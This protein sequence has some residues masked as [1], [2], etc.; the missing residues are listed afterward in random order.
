LQ[1]DSVGRWVLRI[2]GAAGLAVFT[3]VFALTWHRPQWVETVAADFIEDQLAE[4]ISS[5]LE[6]T[7]RAKGLLD[8]FALDL[9]DY[10]DEAIRSLR[11]QLEARV[12][13]YVAQA[14]VEVRDP[15]CTCRLLVAKWL[16][17][18]AATR[19]A[20]LLDEND[21][22]KSFIHTNYMKVVHD[23]EREIRIFTGA[24]AVAFLLLLLVSFAKPAASRH[25]LFPGVLLLIAT[26]VCALLYV[27]SQNW[28][29]TIIHG[30]YVGWAY[31]V[32]LGVVFLFLCDIALNRGRV[33][34][35]LYN[36]ISGALGGVLSALTPC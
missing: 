28:L 11:S 4:E 12:H 10:N 21:R 30:D 27:V 31:A 26:S 5:R 34:T 1:A 3:L 17:A 13:Q 9:S 19:I 8:R 29:L 16:E 15:F 33:T 23:L 25:L 18:G 35:G 6:D 24:N 2:A 32:Y 20:E 36:G 7:N 22:I 14:L